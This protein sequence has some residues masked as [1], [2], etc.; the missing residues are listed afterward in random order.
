MTSTKST[1]IKAAVIG[2]GAAG[3]LC[4]GMLSQKG[5]DV[6]LF[7][8]NSVLGRK[9]LITGKGR[10]NVTNNCPADEVIRNIP[11]NGRFLY[12]AVNAFSPQDVMDFFTSRGVELK[13]ERGKRVFPQSDKAH[14]IQRA[15]V[16][17]CAGC[18]VIKSEVK[19]IIIAD[20]EVK[21]V[22]TAEKDY[23]FDAVAVCTG[24]LSYPLTGSTGDGYRFAKKAGHTVIDPVPSLVPIECREACCEDM[25]GLSLKNVTLTLFD[26]LKNKRLYEEMGEMLFCH[27]GVS[28]PLVLSASAHIGRGD[29]ERAGIKTGRYK[30]LIDLKPAL[31]EQ[32]LNNRILGDFEKYK[33]KNF[34]NAL[35][36]LLP[37]KMI[38]AVVE[39]TGIA[40]FKKVNEITKGERMALIKTLKSFELT[41]SG[42]RPIDE[43]IITSGGVK[44]AEIDPK[45]MQSRLVKGLYF[46]GEVIDA[47]AYT[48]GFNLQIAFSTAYL[49]ARGIAA[50]CL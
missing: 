13:T 38:G 33:N 22:K 6:T 37:A 5:I 31:D 48:G 18:N 14:D 43:A 39:K 24:G 16:S 26:T 3:L 27:F 30:L 19:D 28:G 34:A 44:T 29:D 17:Y 45:T 35:G 46:A 12:A 10:C 11:H 40:P 23:F 9:L 4:A 15:L 41:I 8:K 42:L 50:Q 20:G 49:C 21:G 32:T 2:G 36:D 7:E 47:D 1:M 25:M